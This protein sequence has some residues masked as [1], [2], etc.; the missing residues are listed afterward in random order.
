MELT[1]FSPLKLLRHAD[2]VEA[3]LAGEMI[4]PVSVELDLS[5]TCNHSCPFCSFGTEESQGYR[6]KNWVQF[7]TPRL[8]TLI[9]ELAEVGVKSITFTGGGE[10]LI[11]RAAPAAFE[12]AVVN[13]LQ[14][15]V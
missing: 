13:G 5:L 2:K 7:P 6:Q 12:R 14:F 15:G 10:P 3:M 9:D 1:P 8:L 11:H 4:Y